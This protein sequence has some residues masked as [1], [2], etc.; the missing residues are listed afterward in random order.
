MG[1]GAEDM[2]GSTRSDW[3]PVEELLLKFRRERSR[4]LAMMEGLSGKI[5]IIN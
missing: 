1:G 2:I 3:L 5:S 4:G